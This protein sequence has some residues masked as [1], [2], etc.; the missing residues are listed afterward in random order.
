MGC[1]I[2]PC[3]CSIAALFLLEVCGLELV[4]FLL[5]KHQI[6]W[7]LQLM[8]LLLQRSGMSTRWEGLHRRPCQRTERVGACWC[9]LGSCSMNVC[10]KENVAVTVA[11]CQ[12][13]SCGDEPDRYFSVITSPI[14]P[15][16][17]TVKLTSMDSKVLIVLPY[18]HQDMHQLC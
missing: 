8:S 18:S 14:T 2:F 15:Y 1:S 16:I 6:P 5:W 3:C 17:V 10:E 11:V 4:I 7:Q 12:G 13:I 9:C